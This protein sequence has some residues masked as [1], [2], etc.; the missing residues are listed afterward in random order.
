MAGTLFFVHGTGVRDE[1]YRTTL[2]LIDEGVRRNQLAIDDVRG[3]SWGTPLGVKLDR[4]AD[5]LPIEVSTRAVGGQPSAEEITAAIWIE[6]VEDPY[7]ELRIAATSA[8]KFAATSIAGLPGQDPPAVE[9]R[10][11]LDRLKTNLPDL[12]ATG[13]R[14]D[15]IVSAIVQLSTWDL[16]GR[17]TAAFGDGK[18]PELHEAIARSL[19]GAVLF[20]HRSDPPG[21]QPAL[22]DEVRRRD[23]LVDAL[24]EKLSGASTR[25]I[26]GWLTSKVVNWAKPRATRYLRE[27]RF[28]LTGDSLPA[29]GDI[30]LYQRRGGEILRLIA[31]DLAK[32]PKP[33]LAIGHSLGGI[34]L[35]DL[36]SRQPA[37]AVSLLVTVGSQSPLLYLIDA[38]EGLRPNDPNSAGPFTP[39]LN[40]YDPNDVLSFCAERIFAGRANIHD[41]MVRSE[42]PFPESHSAYWRQDGLYET[43]KTFWNN[44]VGSWS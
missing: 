19:V 35:V 3:T 34:M 41:R 20:S 38:L 22:A 6:L 4:L 32:C 44:K 7:F 15:E 39:W 31:D 9:A 33:V 2:A 14:P 37:P 30:L 23:A 24:A 1:G 13:V 36:L 12:T 26:S 8:P 42:V 29:I 21:C 17:A 25:S 16:F 5:A 43:I 40:I 18:D 27:R 28:G 11:R 10:N